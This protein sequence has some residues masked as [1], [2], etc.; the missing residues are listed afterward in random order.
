MKNRAW[1]LASIF[2]ASA[3]LATDSQVSEPQRCG[4]ECLDVIQKRLAAE[5]KQIAECLPLQPGESR[6]ITRY[7]NP[8]DPRQEVAL[9]WGKASQTKFVVHHRVTRL[10]DPHPDTKKPVF[11]YEIPIRFYHGSPDASVSP[12]VDREFR[13][14]T[15]RC[16]DIASRWL[17]GPNGE[18]ARLRLAPET[19]SSEY[20]NVELGR[21]ANQFGRGDAYHWNPNWECSTL[22]HESLHLLG[23]ADEYQEVSIG[24]ILD[25][26]GKILQEV[27]QKPASLPPGLSFSPRW[28]CRPEGSKGSVMRDHDEAL[29]MVDDWVEHRRCQCFDRSCK[30]KL[31]EFYSS[32]SA[33]CSGKGMGLTRDRW[34]W[35]EIGPDLRAKLDSRK[36][37]IT[38][39]ENDGVVW[40]VRIDA[41][42]PADPHHSALSPTHFRALT[43][44]EH[45]SSKVREYFKCTD[46]SYRSS[47]EP[48]G[49]KELPSACRR[50]NQEWLK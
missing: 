22:V 8:E 37:H 39:K 21:V 24:V 3:A 12:L 11:D 15:N 34:P 50:G 9:N 28:D 14:R 29:K 10:P 16:F 27:Q 41:P 5:S 35:K 33:P 6:L 13:E 47:F 43:E 7:F 20:R 23:L 19:S 1:I 45:C 26:R 25:E 48:G 36:P 38:E 49:C 40:V 44:H 2:A 32:P 4:P 31:A 46:N 30:E 18:H 17:R 42:F